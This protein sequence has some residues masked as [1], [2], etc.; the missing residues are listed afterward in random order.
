MAMFNVFD[1]YFLDTVTAFLPLVLVDPE[2][3]S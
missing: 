3:V 1:D 2:V